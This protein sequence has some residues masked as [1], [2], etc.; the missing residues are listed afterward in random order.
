[1]GNS[2]AGREF[3]E[4][5]R[6]RAL[7]NGRSVVLAANTGPSGAFDPLGRAVGARNQILKREFGRASLPIVDWTTPYQVWGHFPLYLMGVISVLYVTFTRKL[8]KH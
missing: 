7:E 3:M 5:T 6:Y 4:L 8:K 2:N 1:M